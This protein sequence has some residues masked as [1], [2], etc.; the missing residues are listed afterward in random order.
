MSFDPYDNSDGPEETAEEKAASLKVGYETA[1]RA[2]VGLIVRCPSCGHSFQKVS[3][4]Q[5]F[6]SNKGRG[7]CKDVYWNRANTARRE[8]AMI[9]A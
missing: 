3:Y 1:K 7:N 4:Q 9:F 5:A 8:R 2:R 6:C